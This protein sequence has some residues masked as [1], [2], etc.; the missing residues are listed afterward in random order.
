MSYIKFSELFNKTALNYVQQLLFVWSLVETCQFVFTTVTVGN[1]LE[2]LHCLQGIQQKSK[3]S[4]TSLVD[5]IIA[6]VKKVALKQP[7]VNT[8][9]SLDAF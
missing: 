5:D 7:R 2:C 3:R 4:S 1:I 6:E 9:I 8:E